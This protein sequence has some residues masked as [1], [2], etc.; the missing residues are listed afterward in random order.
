[1][2]TTRDAPRPARVTPTRPSVSK[3]LNKVPE[4]T[5]YFWIIKILCTTVGETAAD[6]LNTNLNLG[7]TV[8]TFIMSA[9][10]V[11]ALVFQFRLRHYVPGIYWLAVV[12]ISVVGTLIT[13]N[14]TDNFGVSL[15]T[16]TVV[17]SI[18]LAATFA[19]WYASEKTLSIHTIV[20][21]RREAFYWL[22]VLFTFALGT[23]A[24]DLTAERLAVGYWQSA[25]IFAALIATVYFLHLRF[26]LNA[27][28]AF[29]V[30]Y[31]LTRPLGASIGD[32]LSK[33]HAVGG[34]GLGTTVTSVIFLLTILGVVVYLTLTKKDRIEDRIEV[35]HRRSP[36]AE[37][38][39]A[40]MR[41]L[42][43]ANK[44][45]ATPA[46]VDAVR[47]R[48]AAGPADFV[49][50]VPNPAHLAFDRTS[51][52]LREGDDVLEHALPLLEQAAGA[53]IEGR[54]ATSPNAYDDIVQELN[55][56]DYDE[57]ILETPP[58]HVSHWLHVDLRD[59]I[60]HLGY[61]LTTVTA[62]H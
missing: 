19:A 22:T 17:F 43:V 27:I 16:T 5:L 36:A 7:L 54:V 53:E 57:I 29:W 13:D 60:A 42:V 31:I 21:T 28:L 26:G 44:T 34:R 3:M 8:T 4:V 49:M 20:T 47:E 9:V 24:G 39:A 61:P 35:E 38:A 11:V 15:V 6:F 48:A 51:S 58:S 12:L 56:G 18:V 46:L 14:L 23:A 45:A 55:T 40:G 37:T 2:S 52:D 41:V 62:T 1:M 59:R 50:L 33:P 30:A 25:L 10:L 32:Y